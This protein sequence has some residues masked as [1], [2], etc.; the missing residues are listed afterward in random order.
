MFLNYRNIQLRM[1]MPLRCRI[2][3][4]S[5]ERRCS[6]HILAADQDSHGRKSPR[7]CKRDRT[8]PTAPLLRRS[9]A[10]ADGLGEPGK[11]WLPSALSVPV[12]LIDMSELPDAM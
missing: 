3:V 8:N 4:G 2:L 5:V 10:P 6:C 1:P 7:G 9:S 11:N 12:Q